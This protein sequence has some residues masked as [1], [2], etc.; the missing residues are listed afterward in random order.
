M[1]NTLVGVLSLVTFEA[2]SALPP[3][4]MLKFENPDRMIQ[5]IKIQTRDG[6]R[7]RSGVLQ[8]IV[9]G[10][11]D[12]ESEKQKQFHDCLNYFSALP[13]EQHRRF[14][15]EEKEEISGWH[16]VYPVSPTLM[17]NADEIKKQLGELPKLSEQ[18]TEQVRKNEKKENVDKQVD[19]DEKR[20]PARSRKKNLD[21]CNIV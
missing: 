7:L 19:E 11:K 1:R 2:F 4:T 15:A 14:Y 18:P 17:E 16:M 8:A 9:E 6:E 3:G 13:D 21:I 20:D 12:H 10:I 5:Y